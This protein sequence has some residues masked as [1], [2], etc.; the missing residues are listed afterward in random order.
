MVKGSIDLTLVFQSTLPM[1]GV[2]WRSASSFDTQVVSIHT[3]Y[4][5]SDPAAHTQ[6]E[7]LHVFQ[8]TLP[9]Q[10]VTTAI[11]RC[12]NGAVFQ[13]TLPMQ[14]VTFILFHG[15]LSLLFQSTL[16]MQGVTS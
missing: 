10:G 4:A 12:A 6:R 15:I 9:M 5:G 1:Q 2:T 3:P 11:W 7:V 14:G 13:S 16:P 8:S